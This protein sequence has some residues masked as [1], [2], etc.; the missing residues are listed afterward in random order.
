M[1]V[2]GETTH[3]TDCFVVVLGSQGQCHL[4]SVWPQPLLASLP[5]SQPLLA[6]SELTHFV[7]N[8]VSVRVSLPRGYK[9]GLPNNN[10]NNGRKTDTF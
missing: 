9:G 10:A 8:S 5:V 3:Y 2:R 7:V 4:S 1:S 6:I